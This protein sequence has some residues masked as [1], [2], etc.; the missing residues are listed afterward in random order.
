MEA[1]SQVERHDVA[2]HEA[3]APEAHHV[4]EQDEVLLAHAAK[5]A[6]TAKWPGGE[7]AEGGR[8]DTGCMNDLGLLGWMAPMALWTSLFHHRVDASNYVDKTSESSGFEHEVR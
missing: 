4:D 2:G 8:S 5:H 6:C 1:Q 3:A 7:G